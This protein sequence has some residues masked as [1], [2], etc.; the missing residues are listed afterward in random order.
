MVSTYKLLAEEIDCNSAQAVG[1]ALCNNPFAPKVPCH[2]VISSKLQLHGFHGKTNDE[3]LVQKRK[4]LEDE[5]VRFDD[6]GRVQPDF[7][8]KFSDRQNEKKDTHDEST[9]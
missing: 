2:R 6:Q 4:M 3:A 8:F 5:G 9:F 1:Q 7:V